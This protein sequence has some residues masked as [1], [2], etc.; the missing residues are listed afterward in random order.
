M[1]YNRNDRIIEKELMKADKQYMKA[2]K[3]YSKGRTRRAERQENKAMSHELRAENLAA[4]TAQNTTDAARL[5]TY[6]GVGGVY[7]ASSTSVFPSTGYVNTITTIPATTVLTQNRGPGWRESS[8][9]T[10]TSTTNMGLPT[11]YPAVGVFP[12]ASIIPNSAGTFVGRQSPPSTITTTTT[13]VEEIPA[14]ASYTVASSSSPYYHDSTTATTMPTTTTMTVEQRSE[15]LTT[16]EAGVT[17]FPSSVYTPATLMSTQS[18]LSS[19][20]C[21]RLY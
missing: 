13:M 9:T 11:A 17:S 3:S 4:A 10:A 20:I 2:E 8:Y 5:A 6:H 1:A 16:P 18:P 15:Y 14:T 19:N 21:D 7:P 12:T